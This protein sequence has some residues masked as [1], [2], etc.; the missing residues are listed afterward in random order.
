MAILID[1]FIG[2][3]RSLQRSPE[4]VKKEREREREREQATTISS[5]SI[6]NPVHLTLPH[7]LAIS[8]T[9]AKWKNTQQTYV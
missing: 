1:V 7:G 4:I 5:F 9:T 3:P 6:P 2:I 8:P